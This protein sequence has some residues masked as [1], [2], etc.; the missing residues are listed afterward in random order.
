MEKFKPY[1]NLKLSKSLHISKKSMEAP[2]T[3]ISLEKSRN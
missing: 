2:D 1:K 3:Y